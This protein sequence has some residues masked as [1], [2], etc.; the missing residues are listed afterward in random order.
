MKLKNVCKRVAPMGLSLIM[1]AAGPAAAYAA[2]PEFSK[3]AEEWERLRDNVLEYS[4]IADLVHEYNT[5][6]EANR[7]ELER[8]RRKTVQ[9]VTED[10]WDAANQYG[11]AIF[12]AGD[13]MSAAQAKLNQRQAENAAADNVDDGEIDRLTYAK[14]EAGV[15][16]QAQQHMNTYHQLLI[17]RQLE[18]NNKTYQE[19][20]LNSA[21]V[22]Q[23]VGTATSVDTLK[24]Q[25]SVYDSQAEIINLDA[26]IE[27]S[28]Q[29]LAIMT[30]WKQDG[31]PDI[32]GLPALDLSRIDSIDPAADK[33]T[34]LQNDYSLRIERRRLSHATYSDSQ[35][36]YE[37]NVKKMEESVKSAVDLGYQ[38]IL[39]ART[40]YEQAQLALTVANNNFNAGARKLQVGMLSQVD[41]E[42]LQYKQQTAQTTYQLKEM[43]LFQTMENYD[44]LL[45]GLASS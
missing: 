23:G 9:D 44:W 4:E 37:T 30:G 39:Q 45:A 13:D 25:Q 26:Q 43:E 42:D 40:A 14:A 20:L 32:Q 6:V 3:T 2:S 17:K 12:Y 24:A 35:S 22:K 41:Y 29:N 34:A 5:T 8:T 11:N 31:K 28:R 16:K 27:D 10:Y 7:V 19:K 15:V 18:D 38:N 1:A 21:T 33:E 36:L